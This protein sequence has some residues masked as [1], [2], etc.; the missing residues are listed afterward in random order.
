MKYLSSTPDIMGGDL[1]IKGTRIPVEVILYRLKDGY[2]LD[3]IHELYP[4]PTLDTLKGAIGEAIDLLTP[5]LHGKA[6]LQT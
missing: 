3:E 4:T 1:V 2:W 5:S 6:V